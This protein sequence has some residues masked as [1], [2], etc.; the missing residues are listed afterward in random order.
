[1]VFQKTLDWSK[2]LSLQPNTYC[3]NLEDLDLYLSQV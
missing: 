3:E 2:N 1:M